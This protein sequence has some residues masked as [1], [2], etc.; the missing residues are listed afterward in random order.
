MKPSA[1]DAY[2]FPIKYNNWVIVDVEFRERGVSSARYYKCICN[3]GEVKWQRSDSL[4]S[5]KLGCIKCA[6][7]KLALGNVTH[8][9]SYAS[10]YNSWKG[11][12]RRCYNKKDIGYKNYGGRGII[13]CNEWRHSFD[14][15][16]KCVGLKPTV[17]HTIERINN[18]GNYEPS[19]C[20]WATRKE[21]ANNRRNSKK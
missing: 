1:F 15:F 12:L 6:L 5:N 19:N 18:D 2:N 16:I 7:N 17:K 20:C 10:E 13:V 8:G 4:K 3:C 14:E 9:L 11:M 21:Q